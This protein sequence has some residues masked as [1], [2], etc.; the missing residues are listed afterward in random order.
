M[1]AYPGYL[2]PFYPPPRRNNTNKYILIGL[3]VVICFILFYPSEYFYNGE[4]FMLILD[5]YLI[6]VVYKLKFKSNDDTDDDANK[7]GILPFEK[8]GVYVKE[9]WSLFDLLMLS[10]TSNKSINLIFESYKPIG[11]KLGED[12]LYLN[13]E[14]SL[15]LL[16]NDN[17]SNRMM[18]R[19]M[20][21]INMA[22]EKKNELKASEGFL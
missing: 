5:E 12:S 3:L 17:L 6:D 8:P 22:K 15:L 7:G 1:Q 14:K 21:G 11:V 20:N 9:S 13:R 19:M 2:P 16:E 4:V 18:N 10:I